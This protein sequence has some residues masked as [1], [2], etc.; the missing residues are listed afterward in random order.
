[1]PGDLEGSPALT[2]SPLALDE[3][4]EIVPGS[5]AAMM[6]RR[7]EAYKTH[8]ARPFFRDHFC[9]LDRQI[10]L[11]DALSALELRPRRARR[12][13][14]RA[15]RDSQRLPRRSRQLL[16]TLFRPR[17]EKI[18]F[19]ATKADHL[20]HVSH[21]R[22]EAL[23]KLVTDRAI[24]RADRLGGRGRRR[25]AGGDTGDARSRGAQRR[26]RA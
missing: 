23:L 2:F 25:R 7:F 10:V 21:D 16:S 12:P 19:A 24:S 17:I 13:R 3:Y 11:V 4:I 5:L 20:H 26:R 18:L 1:M 9:R 8:V 22:L 14:A 6:A 15:R